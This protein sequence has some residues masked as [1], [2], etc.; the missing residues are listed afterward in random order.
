MKG[1]E[2]KET[3]WVQSQ[4]GITECFTSN[5]T[6]TKQTPLA[7]KIHDLKLDGSFKSVIR[8]TRFRSTDILISPL[9]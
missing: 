2:T 3:L 1:A 7:L 8:C 6:A 4:V 9:A 5:L